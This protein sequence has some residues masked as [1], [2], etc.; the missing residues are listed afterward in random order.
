MDFQDLLEHSYLKLSTKEHRKSF[1]QF[2][3]P[4]AIASLMAAYILD[5]KECSR[6]LD[7][8]NGLNIFARALDEHLKLINHR[9]FDSNY[10]ILN[11]LSYATW[12][13]LN[14]QQ[15][16]GLSRLEQKRSSLTSLFY[17]NQELHHVLALSQLPLEVC[18]YNTTH[19][20]KVNT[21][22]QACSTTSK[23]PQSTA[24]PSFTLVQASSYYTEQGDKQET[25][26][27]NQESVPSFEQGVSAK[28]SLVSSTIPSV[29]A[30][31][32]AGE[33]STA[34]AKEQDVALSVQ[35]DKLNTISSVQASEQA[36]KPS[37]TQARESSN[38]QYNIQDSTAGAIQENGHSIDST[39]EP[40]ATLSHA[41]VSAPPALSNTNLALASQSPIET[42]QSQGASISAQ[43]ATLLNQGD[44]HL[45]SV[46]VLASTSQLITSTKAHQDL[47]EPTQEAKS[48]HATYTQAPHLEQQGVTNLG[49]SV[50][51]ASQHLNQE[52]KVHYSKLE[53][54]VHVQLPY[55]PS[56]TLAQ[57][58]SGDT[59]PP[60]EW[61]TNSPRFSMVEQ[62]TT[63]HTQ[64]ATTQGTQVVLQKLNDSKLN[65]TKHKS[66]TSQ[67]KVAVNA[68]SNS[69]LDSNSSLHSANLDT[70]TTKSHLVSV[71][72]LLS[73]QY[74]ALEPLGKS[75]FA[76][77]SLRSQL[78]LS[79]ST[80]QSLYTS[81]SDLKPCMDMTQHSVT[82]H[83]LNACPTLLCDKQ[84]LD[85]HKLLPACQVLGSEVLNLHLHEILAQAQDLL[86]TSSQVPSLATRQPLTNISLLSAVEH[87][88]PISTLPTKTNTGVH[89]SE[90]VCLE[91]IV[92][93]NEESARYTALSLQGNATFNQ[94]ASADTQATTTQLSTNLVAPSSLTP[95]STEEHNTVDTHVPATKPSLL[96][97]HASLPQLHLDS[98]PSLP[99]HTPAHAHTPAHEY[100]QANSHTQAQAQA[101]ANL[102]V[103]TNLENLDTTN[104]TA[105]AQLSQENKEILCL[106][107]VADV[108]ERKVEL[109]AYEVDPIIAEFASLSAAQIPMRYVNMDF[110][111][112][113][114]L[115][116]NFK[117]RF[118]GII[119]N[120]PYKTFKE[121][122]R[123]SHSITLI[124][125]RL[126]L[127][128]SGRTN[129]YALFL[130][131]SLSQLKQNGRCAYLIPYEFLTNAA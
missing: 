75:S 100:P 64:Q 102:H 28:P 83:S 45:A 25:S 114:Y 29:P 26:S 65:D 111:L 127:K 33:P 91:G 27:S 41:Q 87:E 106:S 94:I 95:H 31:E 17:N 122:A 123:K 1:A 55:N 70:H 66:K 72:L 49:S 62:A 30:S 99:S 58:L 56:L 4:P 40:S 16:L 116:S 44:S 103:Q 110:R 42:K 78:N 20:P 21:S 11:N 39:L 126:D 120:P 101:Q 80:A 92:L 34:Q 118:D 130:L 63:L 54:G 107:S 46:S 81:A 98:T 8:A 97:T 43:Q 19:A 79:A 7:P 6:I 119:C 112:K 13:K 2:F 109:V 85:S 88:L 23:P 18:L 3:T 86:A 131:K 90:S 84:L 51:S 71:S 82:A 10:Q 38:A 12:P 61:F 59:Y 69:S 74:E 121:F 77:H 96:A 24:H 15:T 104:H 128:L 117:E 32:Q 52:A 9:S 36:R 124:E 47:L 89:G 22:T 48:H 57:A 37:T 60:I 125:E 35:A 50:V 14:Q 67:S 105:Q 73:L 5:K 129:L 53:S 115:K 68:T 76:S 108:T 93:P 113:D